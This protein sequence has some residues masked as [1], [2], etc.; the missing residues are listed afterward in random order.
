MIFE[1]RGAGVVASMKLFGLKRCLLLSI[2]VCIYLRIC[3]VHYHHQHTPVLQHE[4]GRYEICLFHIIVTA[5]LFEA[6]EELW[7]EADGG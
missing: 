4:S 5:H 2:L 1:V 6:T 3:R 7:V